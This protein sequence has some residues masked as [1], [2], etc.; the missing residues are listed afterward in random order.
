[1]SRKFCKNCGDPDAH[2]EG[3]FCSIDCADL[4][5]GIDAPCQREMIKGK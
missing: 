4:Y 1:M 5:D 3:K 2:F